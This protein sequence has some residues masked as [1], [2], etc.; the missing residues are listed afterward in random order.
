MIQILVGTASRR[1]LHD[2]AA[3]GHR[4][5]RDGPIRSIMPLFAGENLS[6][7][8]KAVRKRTRADPQRELSR[9]GKRP[10]RF[11]CVRHRTA[12]L[13]VVDDFQPHQNGSPRN[14]RSVSYT[15]LSAVVSVERRYCCN[16]TCRAQRNCHLC[17]LDTRERVRWLAGSSCSSLRVI[18]VDRSLDLASWRSPWLFVKIGIWSSPSPP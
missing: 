1:A 2:H 4:R 9:L 8:M 7:R 3:R 12:R 10:K 18:C 15:K 5:E 16:D 11:R 17:T 13:Q 14:P 6:K